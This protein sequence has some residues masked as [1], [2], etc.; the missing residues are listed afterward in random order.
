MPGVADESDGIDLLHEVGWGLQVEARH[1][2]SDGDELQG[3]LPGNGNAPCAA[4]GGK[5]GK[6]LW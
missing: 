3:E 1:V 2:P 4:P 6:I 5:G